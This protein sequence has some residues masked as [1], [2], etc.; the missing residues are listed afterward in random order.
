LLSDVKLGINGL[1]DRLVI[2]Q[3]GVESTKTSP[4]HGHDLVFRAKGSRFS[5]EVKYIFDCTYTK[6]YVYA[7]PAD[8]DKHPNYQVVFFVSFPNY[9]YP[10]GCWS[11]GR[12]DPR[13]LMPARE[14]NIVGIAAQYAKVC[15]TLGRA[16]SWP[17]AQCPYAVDL[18]R[19]TETLSE[20]RIQRTL[21]RLFR[22]TKA[23]RF[24][25]STDLEGAQVG[26]AIWD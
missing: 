11:G 26:F 6:Y 2:Q 21:A 1:L 4:S 19:E 14:I 17:S 16:A 7:V 9:R 23:W 20:D 3:A 18:P 24:S 10:A 12:R 22:P 5:V 13:R 15:Q 25:A 8:R